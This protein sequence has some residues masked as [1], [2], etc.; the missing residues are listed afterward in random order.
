MK[1]YKWLC[2]GVLLST[3]LSGCVKKEN[4]V[5]LVPITYS[6]DSYVDGR[7]VD[8][9]V[10]SLSVP[11]YSTQEIESAK[12][13]SLEDM[14]GDSL[15]DP[16][17]MNTG[18]D[19]FTDADYEEGYKILFNIHLKKQHVVFHK[20]RVE[21]NGKEYLAEGNYDIDFSHEKEEFMYMKGNEISM[22]PSFEHLDIPEHAKNFK[23][24]S[25]NELL[26]IDD[27]FLFDEGGML[28]YRI[29]LQEPYK[30]YSTSLILQYEVDGMT[31]QKIL[32]G[33]YGDETHV[34][35]IEK[36]E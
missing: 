28:Q 22:P 21:I 36:D 30:L 34:M 19:V 26:S 8:V 23:L 7:G 5:T 20:I 31:Y 33:F 11:F 27:K 4:V 10:V 13:L 16:F 14:E 35:V 12:V 32:P 17:F 15:L 18:W 25:D 1:Y 9:Q 29:T 3:L 6:L 24:L 2:M